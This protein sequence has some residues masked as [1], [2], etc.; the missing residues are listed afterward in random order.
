MGMGPCSPFVR[1]SDHSVQQP[2]FTIK[3]FY[4]ISFDDNRPYKTCPSST[5]RFTNG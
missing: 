5:K 2:I 1:S 3:I 4:A